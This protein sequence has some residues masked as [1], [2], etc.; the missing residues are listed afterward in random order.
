M[1][2]Y[3]NISFSGFYR[4][5][6]PADLLEGLSRSFYGFF[7][8]ICTT[9][10][11]YSHALFPGRAFKDG[12]HSATV[13]TFTRLF[14]KSNL[15]VLRVWQATSKIGADLCHKIWPQIS[16]L[17]D[18]LCACVWFTGGKQA[19]SSSQFRLQ[20]RKPISVSRNGR[21]SSAMPAMQDCSAD[22]NHT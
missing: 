9:S 21:T 16:R 3:D 13:G 17:T 10:M 19:Q 4:S 8:A 7:H 20:N 2:T 18:E 12:Y 6:L 22:A 5:D 15:T 1:N 11:S 14:V